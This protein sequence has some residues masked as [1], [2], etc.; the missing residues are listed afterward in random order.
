MHRGLGFYH[1]QLSMLGDANGDGQVDA[2]ERERSKALPKDAPR[3]DLEVLLR[4]VP[5]E[6]QI[7]WCRGAGAGLRTLAGY[8]RDEAGA[9]R[10]M[11]VRIAQGGDARVAHLVEGACWKQAYAPPARLVPHLINR[12]TEV[13]AALH[14]ADFGEGQDADVLR[15]AAG[16]SLGIF[17][18]RLMARDFEPEVEGLK[19]LFNGQVG[20]YGRSLLEGI[21]VGL[22]DNRTDLGWPT[23]MMDRIVQSDSQG[24][25]A[26]AF[27]AECRRVSRTQFHRAFQVVP[28]ELKASLGEDSP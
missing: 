6:Y 9:I 27:G 22:V 11:L 28:P 8:K 20:T 25:V 19:R 10:D 7:D 13:A 26:A 5:Q 3:L 17:M 15:A 4:S 18:G 12:A 21:G 23:L 1:A 16:R 2:E 24:V 14:G